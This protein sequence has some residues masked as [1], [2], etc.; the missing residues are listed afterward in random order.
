MTDGRTFTEGEAYALVADNVARETAAAT[1]R[2]TALQAENSDLQ[3][4]ITETETELHNRIDVLET[5][6]AAAVER[7]GLAE[8]A[9]TDFKTDIENEK[10]SELRRVDRTGKV[11][12]AAPDLEMTDERSARIVAM[13]DEGFESYLSDLREVAKAA[14]IAAWPACAKCGAKTDPATA[15]CE[16]CGAAT[17]VKAAADPPE[18]DADDKQKASVAV[19][20]E[21]AAFHG[22]S[23]TSTPKG[24]VKALIGAGR[25]LTSTNHA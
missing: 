11:A 10:A 12:D 9:L 8:T 3:T 13:D 20:R 2:I 24:T 14:G 16:K 17:P 6:K 4:R 22:D 19:P 18:P 25:A 5:E 23:A 21:S 7:A 1:E 15:K